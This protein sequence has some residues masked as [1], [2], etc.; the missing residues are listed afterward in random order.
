YQLR[1]QFIVPN[2]PFVYDGPIVCDSFIVVLCMMYSLVLSSEVAVI[3]LNISLILQSLYICVCI[4]S[5]VYFYASKAMIACIF[6]FA[7]YV[8]I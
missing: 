7:L 1:H 5:K 8:H 3:I 6:F 2:G 4:S